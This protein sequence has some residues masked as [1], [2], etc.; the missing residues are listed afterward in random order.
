MPRLQ[1]ESESSLFCAGAAHPQNIHELRKVVRHAHLALDV[2]KY[3]EE[4]YQLALVP[5]GESMAGL[6]G[7]SPVWLGNLFHEVDS[8]EDL[9]EAVMGADPD[10]DEVQTVPCLR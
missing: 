3:L 2:T 4:R 5:V 6:T 9:I 1:C 8:V 10:D 7:E